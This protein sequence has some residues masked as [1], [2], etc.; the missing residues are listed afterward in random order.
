MT[1]RRT[2]LHATALFIVCL[3][4]LLVLIFGPAG[5]VG[6]DDH[7][8]ARIS[9]QIIEQ[10]RLALDFPWLPRTIL[11]ADRFV[12][13]HLL[14]H[15]F[16]APWVALG[17]MAGA[18]VA[19][20]AIAAAAFTMVWVFLRGIGARYATVWA[21]A[22]FAIS[23]PFLYR[24][25]MIR[26]QGASLLLLIV[27][28]HLLAQRHYRWLIGMGFAYTWLYDGFVLVPLFAAAYVAA[29][30]IAD[31][32]LVWRPLAYSVIGVALGLVINPYFPHNLE[33]IAEHLGAK[34][35]F[36]QGV[37]VGNEW[38][39]YRTSTLL[40]NST[41]A[42]ALLVLG[43]LWP[44]FRRRRADAITTTLLLVALLTLYMVFRSRRFIEYFPAFALLYAAVSWGRD[45]VALDRLLPRKWLWQIPALGLLIASTVI[46]WNATRDLIGEG[47][48]PKYLA[49]ASAWLRENTP[50]GAM[51]FQTD[52]DDFPYLFYHNT[53][54]VYLVGLDPTY[55]QEAD[56]ELWDLWVAITRGEIDA[57]STA[58]E[59]RFGARYVVSDRRHP[60]FTRV[61][62]ADPR[63][64]MV[65][66][67]DNARVWEVL[68]AGSAP[69]PEG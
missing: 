12:D 58:I 16:L 21:L 3:I 66:E 51:V 35:N 5:F 33:F 8:H 69:E 44:S 41:G 9:E 20:A 2:W 55:L 52:W 63:M 47:R 32:K 65:Y 15:L 61:A 34:T 28:L 14:F 4:P 11:S 54:N 60:D 23:S 68:P 22:M 46:T 18:K 59:T 64:H 49:G 38:Y 25:L 42:L 57:P 30:W 10:R 48:D 62:R 27:T 43:V 45:G 37:Q 36:Q 6:T 1:T 24:L 53:H 31:R 67:D 50:R 13:H 29:T 19:T 40:D 56:P 17:G 7:Y 26:T 39:A